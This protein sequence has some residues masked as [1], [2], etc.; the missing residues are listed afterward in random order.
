VQRIL[1][2]HWP[3]ANP[4]SRATVAQMVVIAGD[5]L[6]REAFRTTLDG[7]QVVLDESK[8]MLDAY[9]TVRLHRS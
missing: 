2:V 7:D 4:E 5:G 8:A 9:V 3:Q 1:A 6:L